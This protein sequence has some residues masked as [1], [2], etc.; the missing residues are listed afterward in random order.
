MKKALALSVVL[1]VALCGAAQARLPRTYAEFKERYATEGKT[2]R[3]AVKMYFEAVYAYL[4]PQLREEASK[5]VRYALH[6]DRP[7]ERSQNYATFAERLR[8]PSYAHIFRSFA[9]G[10]S[11]EDDY[12]MSP[13]DFELMFED[14]WEDPGGYLRVALRSSGADSPRTIQVK[15]YD[16]LWY[17][18]NNA[19]TYVEVRRPRSQTDARRNAHDADFDSGEGLLDRPAR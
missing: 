4:D 3:G 8:D 18:I 10:T 7:I 12:A 1:V 17:V 11:P 19:G 6:S 13:D 9:K 14:A 5:M 16:G 15:D 2:P